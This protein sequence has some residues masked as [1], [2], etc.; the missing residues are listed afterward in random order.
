[1][2]VGGSYYCWGS[3]G[4]TVINSL[5]PEGVDGRKGFL[6]FVDVTKPNRAHTLM[7]MLRALILTTEILRDP[8]LPFVIIFCG[9][10]RDASN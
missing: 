10:S 6:A 3:L 1:M 8:W 2:S 7:L 5:E 4:S 9:A